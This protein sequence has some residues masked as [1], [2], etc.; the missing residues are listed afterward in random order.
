MTAVR[1]H[2]AAKREDA[3]DFLPRKRLD[4][5]EITHERIGSTGFHLPQDIDED[6]YPARD[7]RI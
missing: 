1:F 7:F 2:L 4:G 5:K 3:E 6:F